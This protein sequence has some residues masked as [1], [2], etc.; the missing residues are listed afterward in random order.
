DALWAM[1]FWTAL[2][3]AD[4][5]EAATGL[6]V[7]LHWPNDLLLD[8]RKCCG[9]LCISR[10]AGERAWVGCGT[11]VNVRRPPGDASLEA[12]SPPPA[13]LSDDAPGVKRAIVLDAILAAYERRLSALTSPHEIAREWETRSQL[14]GTPY[15][16]LID[17]TTDPLD[18]IAQ[19]LDDDGS[20]IVESNGSE[21]R[22]MLA[23]AR[24]L[25]S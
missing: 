1:T 16:L 20:L 12:V 10:V 11:G 18:A 8:G 13:F 22:I 19:R 6:R 3:V 4:G 15:R 5:I 25:R 9:I 14:H 7:G 23:D 2:G 24:V 17:G 21:R